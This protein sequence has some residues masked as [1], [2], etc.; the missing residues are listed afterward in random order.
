M[1]VHSDVQLRMARYVSLAQFQATQSVVVC[2]RDG[3]IITLP[4]IGRFAGIT[5]TVLF[6]NLPNPAA[7][8]TLASTC[9]SG[10][11]ICQG[12]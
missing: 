9:L 10:A 11:A 5:K 4:H 6:R 8:I 3:W 1:L 7:V 2:K 12:K